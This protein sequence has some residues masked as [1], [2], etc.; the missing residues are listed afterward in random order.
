MSFLAR[1]RDWLFPRPLTAEEWRLV[2][3]TI[4]KGEKALQA[5][6]QG[7]VKRATEILRMKL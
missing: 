3:W 5:L 2:D 1:V 6:Q 7:D 4:Y